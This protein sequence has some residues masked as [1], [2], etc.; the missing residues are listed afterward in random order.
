MAHLG[1][2]KVNTNYKYQKL[3]DVTGLTFESGKTYLIQT[4]N[5]AI[6]ITSDTMPTKGGFIV[7]DTKLMSYTHEDG[8]DLYIKTIPVVGAI[9]NIAE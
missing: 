9:V 5:Y 2:F 1:E 4:Q 8:V 6:Y 7:N 3:S